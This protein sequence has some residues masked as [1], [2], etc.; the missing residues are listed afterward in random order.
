MPKCYCS[1]I[2]Q[3]IGNHMWFNVLLE[4]IKVFSYNAC[5]YDNDRDFDLISV[6]KE[7]IGMNEG[8]HKS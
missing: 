3:A 6:F 7:V 8:N 4:V 1:P 5:N 2:S